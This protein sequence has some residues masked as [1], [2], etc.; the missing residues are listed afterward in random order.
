MA[1]NISEFN[2]DIAKSSIAH[3]SHF[4]GWILGGPG[5]YPGASGVPGD[6]LKNS[7]L[8][9]GM[10]FRIELSWTYSRYPLSFHTTTS[11]S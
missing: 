7:G 5:S 2:S 3:T 8:T 4:E 11:D 6:S 1:F 9:D 10:R